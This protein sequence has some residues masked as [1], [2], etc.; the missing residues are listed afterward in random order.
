MDTSPLA[1][2]T[3]MC[4]NPQQV[5]LVSKR[6][7]SGMSKFSSDMKAT[8]VASYAVSLVQ[9]SKNPKTQF[10]EPMLSTDVTDPALRIESDDAA[11]ATERED[12]KE[13]TLSRVRRP[14]KDA[15]LVALK[16]ESA[17]K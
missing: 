3:L 9:S 11:L 5:S 4:R 12:P 8:T 15:T 1:G 13:T 6:P 17:L 2:S 7:R 10:V 14:P 16:S